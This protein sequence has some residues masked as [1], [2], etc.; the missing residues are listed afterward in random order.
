MVEV[1]Y[2]LNSKP[3]IARLVYALICELKILTSFIH[4]FLY[5]QPT[6][7][8]MQAIDPD[9]YK[10]LKMILEYNLE[11]IGLDLTFS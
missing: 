8:D 7:H 11:D 5:K 6:H 3:K 4:H 10:N 1:Q 2:G 9:Y